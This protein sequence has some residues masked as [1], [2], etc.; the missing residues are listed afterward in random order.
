[1]KNISKLFLVS[2]LCVFLSA[3]EGNNEKNNNNHGVDL[4]NNVVNEIV[5]AL[6]D[7]QVGWHY[8]DK[9]DYYDV[10]IEVSNSDGIMGVSCGYRELF[11][12]GTSIGGVTN[13][14]LVDGD[15]NNGTYSVEINLDKNASKDAVVLEIVIFDSNDNYQ[16]SIPYNELGI[17]E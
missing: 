6:D 8:L 14:N 10:I 2:V 15:A 17:I 3:C 9:Y 1:M 11:K 12:D 5:V 4:G 16:L 7:S 13:M